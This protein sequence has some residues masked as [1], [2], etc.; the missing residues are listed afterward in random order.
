MTAIRPSRR[1]PPPRHVVEVV[2]TDGPTAD[3]WDAFVESVPGAD[4]VQSARWGRSKA[5]LGFE[6]L[7]LVVWRGGVIVGGAQLVLKRLPLFGAVAYVAAGPVVRPNDAEACGQVVTQ[8]GH[9]ARSLRLRTIVVQPP[10]DAWEVA[11]VLEAA[12]FEPSPIEIA[13]SATCLVDVGC[14]DEEILAQMSSTRR[15]LIRR[16]ARQPIEVRIGA[17][18]IADFTA[19]HHSTSERQGFSPRTAAYLAAQWDELAESGNVEVFVAYAGGRPAAGIWVSA[20]GERAV[21]RHSGW[22]GGRD[23]NV[24]EACHWA[25]MRW[26]RERGCD[27]YDLGGFHR[28]YAELLAA[29]EQLPDD[30]PDRWSHL[31]FKASFGG[32]MVV[33]PPPLHGPAGGLVRA[34]ARALQALDLPILDRAVER[35]RN[36]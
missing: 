18:T 34:G 31:R 33:A 10:A 6:V 22:A 8:L 13:P 3:L 5:R 21:F 14:A 25:A 26:A 9:M 16:S 35:L 19:L 28:P 36:G 32:Q 11:A 4:I 17:S 24:N 1:T 29:G 2:T 23:L 7:L 12:G 15:R 30:L 27:W 20:F